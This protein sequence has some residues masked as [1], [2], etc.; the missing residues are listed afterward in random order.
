MAL[1][2]TVGWVATLRVFRIN[3][4]SYKAVREGHMLNY[5]LE[6]TITFMIM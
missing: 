2:G 4:L 3:S 5:L 1:R 6:V